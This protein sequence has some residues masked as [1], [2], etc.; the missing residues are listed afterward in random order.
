[1][2]TEYNLIF[3]QHKD[4]LNKLE[5]LSPAKRQLLE[6]RLSQ[7]MN[8][9]VAKTKIS[10][11]ATLTPAFASFAQRRLWF[12][13]Q[14]KPDNSVYNIPLVLH[15]AGELNAE[16]LEAA[17]NALVAR[18]ETLRTCFTEEDGEPLQE[19]AAKVNVL[20]PIDE[21]GG[22]SEVVRDMELQ[23]RLRSEI[24]MPFDLAQGPLLRVRLFK[25]GKATHVLV[26][27]L[28]HIIADG[29]SIGVLMRD[30]SALYYA[31]HKSMPSPLPA[32]PVQY[33]DYA[34]WQRDCFQCAVLEKQLSYWREQ[35]KDLTVLELPTDRPRPAI[36]RFRGAQVVF[37]MTEAVTKKLELLCQRAGSTLFMTLLAAFQV[38]LQRYSG[39]DDIVVGSPIAGRITTEIESLIGFFVNTLVLRTDLSGNPTFLELLARVR[40]MA[41]NAYAHQDIPFDKLVEESQADRD[42]SRNPLFQIAFV[43][44]NTPQAELDLPG[45]K[46]RLLSAQKA[47]AKF[48]LTLIITKKSGE[49]QGLLEYNTDLFDAIT[50]ECLANHFHNL[51][52]D[53]LSDPDQPLSELSLLSDSEQ[54]QL[55][56]E[57]NATATDY[58]ADQCIHYLFEAQ[59]ANTP[60]ATALVMK[61]QR[62]NYAELNAQ[63]NQLAHHLRKRGIGPDTLVGIALHRSIEL[64]TGILGILK[65]G[66]AY[67]PLDP[68]YPRERL[69]FMLQDTDVQVLL[70][71]HSLLSRFTDYAGQTVCLDRD[72]PLIAQE[73]QG[74][75]PHT[76]VTD[77]L[78]YIIY[79]SGS[80]GTPK[81]VMVPHRGVL[82]LVCSIDYIRLSADQVHVFLAPVSFDA[83]TFELWGALLHGAQCVIFP[84]DVPTIERLGSVIQ[85]HRVTTLWL[86]ASLFNM[87]IDESPQILSG[88]QQLLTGGEALSVPHVRRALAF[89]PETRLFNCYGPTESTTFTCSYPIPRI[90]DQHL[91]SVPIGRPIEN[92]TIYILDRNRKPVPAGVPGEM[93][94]GGDGLARGYLNQ[95]SLTAEK[96]V[97]SPF[98]KDHHSCLYKTG[99]RVRY[100]TDG[101]IEFLGRMDRQ[102]KIRGFRIEPGEVE[103]NLESHDAV[104]KSIVTVTT[105]EAGGKQLIAYIMP[106]DGYTPDADSLR[107]YLK[108]R[109]PIYMI[110]AYYMFLDAFPLSPN[111]KIDRDALPHP[112]ES[113]QLAERKSFVAPRNFTEQCIAEIWC[114]LLKLEKVGIHENFFNLGGH[115]LLATQVINRLEARFEL[116]IPL[117]VIFD[118]PSVIG[119]AAYVD[120]LKGT[121]YLDA[122]SSQDSGDDNRERG[123]I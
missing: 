83:S 108:E 20:L 101:N 56:E 102:I 15:L 13:D 46:T 11:R 25:L 113:G 57:W 7:H 89:L 26:L 1:M 123:I 63:A 64:V 94:I 33:A 73:Q 18:H 37:F 90:L 41:L 30:L 87:I 16:A 62:I 67:V 10:R 86:N 39:Q 44:Q 9:S 96:F 74:N 17:L 31:Y 79:T 4:L 27:T 118:F 68:T 38:L 98:S 72:W 69:A 71:E 60:D 59:A 100:L 93:Y 106:R 54:R 95:E 24:D 42:L 58:P 75:P 104:N 103:N 21:L 6:N 78:A 65:A 85:Q 40:E 84:Q 48:D 61:N 28:H 35:L 50:V 43:L 34:I 53:I 51:L 105:D 82:R 66:G 107:N 70:T 120:A 3:K 2:S 32:L 112:A 45:I 115:S 91:S 121:S 29:W 80:T 55:L 49:L 52:A 47:T 76:T 14:F 99:D 8:R 12:L 109:I 122:S 97:D 23:K 36:Q 5:Q 117:G 92:T 119:L 110:P 19:I 77:N 88:V 81:G 116:E 114:T 111:G 22:M